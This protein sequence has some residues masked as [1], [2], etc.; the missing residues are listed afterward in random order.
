MRRDG[1]L[2]DD[3][4]YLLQGDRISRGD[5]SQEEQISIDHFWMWERRKVGCHSRHQCYE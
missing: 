2:V 5:V 1:P 4:T 3:A